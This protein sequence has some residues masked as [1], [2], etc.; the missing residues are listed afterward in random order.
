MLHLVL[1][2]NLREIQL[3]I[4]KHLRAFCTRAEVC[5]RL[6][7]AVGNCIHGYLCPWAHISPTLARKTPRFGQGVV[8]TLDWDKGLAGQVL[9]PHGQRFLQFANRT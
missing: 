2:I 8:C 4:F 9:D 7:P 6:R 5:P 3:L 1:V